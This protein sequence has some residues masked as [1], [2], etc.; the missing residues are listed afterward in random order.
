MEKYIN[1]YTDFGFKRLFGTEPNKAILIEFLNALFEAEQDPAIDRH[2][3]T[4]LTYLPGEQLGILETD[5]RAVFDV[6]CQTASGK[7]IVVEMQN[8]YQQFYKDRV[9]YYSSIPIYEQGLRGRWNFELNAV[10]VVSIMNFSFSKSSDESGEGTPKYYHTRVMLMDTREKTI[11]SDKLTLFFLEMKKFD[12]TES[13]LTTQ[14]DKWMY[15]LKNIDRLMALP[16]GISEPVFMQFMEQAEIARFTRE[17]RQRYDR[18]IMAYRDVENSVDTARAEG[19]EKG[20]KAGM[21]KGL[22]EGEEKGLKA[23]MEKGRNEGFLASIRL[24]MDNMQMTA[25]QAM[26]VLE[27]PEKMRVMYRSSLAEGEKHGE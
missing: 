26:D 27:I 23:G 21:E 22:K 25:E 18:S 2:V 24:L 8:S 15:L 5:R 12:K 1:P 19:E 3:I 17:E 20:L 16:K 10:Y 14:L 13:E 9:I 6:Y 7:K 4:D 11:F